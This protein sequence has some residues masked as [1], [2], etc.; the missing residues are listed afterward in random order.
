MVEKKDEGGVEKIVFPPS[1][2]EDFQDIVLGR[3]GDQAE[4]KTSNFLRASR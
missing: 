3:R 1:R 2:A 4:E